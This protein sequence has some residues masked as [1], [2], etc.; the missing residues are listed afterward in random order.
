[1]KLVAEDQP[2]AITELQRST[3]A[4]GWGGAE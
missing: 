2:T 4:A 1:M 3:R